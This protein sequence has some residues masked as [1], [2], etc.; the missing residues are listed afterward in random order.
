MTPLDTAGPVRDFLARASARQSVHPGDG[1]GGAVFESV[2]V[3]GTAYFVKRLSRSADWV[4][5]ASG[6]QV[7]RPYLVWQAGIM[8]R[9]P[10]CID[11]TVVAMGL[12]GT[13]DDAVITVLMR[14]V[15][16]FAIARMQP[17]F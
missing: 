13:G 17:C 3:D 8:D 16:T 14:D 11:H 7:H 6:D 2:T 12:E 9:A 15:G 5:R 10:G 1:K 4:M